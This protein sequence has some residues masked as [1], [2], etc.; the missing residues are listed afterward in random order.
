MVRRWRRGDPG[1]LVRARQSLCQTMRGITA[2]ALLLVMVVMIP[3]GAWAACC[4]CNGCPTGV[5][6]FSTG[7][8]EAQDCFDML[9]PSGCGDAVSNSALPCSVF[10][11]DCTTIDGTPVPSKTPTATVTA[12]PTASPVPQGG[13]CTTPSQCGTGFCANGV[14]CDSACTGPLMRCNL[15]G[16]LG[17]CAS[18]AAAAPTLT[19]WG[20]LAASLLLASIAAAALRRRMRS[21]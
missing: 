16:Q 5:P 1:G 7:F 2:C 15:S 3:A 9:C 19:A 11:G 6:C 14:C 10:P 21:R 18:A 4:R 17:T 13:A 8:F 20:L 12:T